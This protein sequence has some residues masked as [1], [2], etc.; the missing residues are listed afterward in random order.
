MTF[1]CRA[2]PSAGLGKLCSIYWF[3]L[4]AYVRRRGFSPHDA[5]DLTQEFLARLIGRE[6]LSHL[7][8]EGGKF[9]AYLLTALKHFLANT[10]DGARTQKRGGKVTLI[11]WDE[12]KAEHWLDL[13][14]M[15]LTTPEQTYERRWA[16]TV[17]NTVMGRLEAEYAASG[18]A[19]LFA[20]LQ[21][22][23]VGGRGSESHEQLSARIG[24]SQGAVRVALHRL[25]R[26][27][28]ELLR[29]EVAHTVS[30]TSEI[31]E[32]IRH[33]ISAACG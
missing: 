17:L 18:K 15:D 2:S 22:A 1:A 9:R 25:R 3:P 23:I 21:P 33:L 6:Y 13:G 8:R 27:Y 32:E 31:D 10:W 29:E 14:P 26:R 24:T 19:D 30:S 5:E 12:S 16:V 4:Y 7:S 11:S 28:G 20:L